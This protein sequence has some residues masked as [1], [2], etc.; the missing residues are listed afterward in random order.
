MSH[1]EIC[2]RQADKLNM[3][4]LYEISRSKLTGGLA[5]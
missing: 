3:Q 5:K 1:S 2:Y 4:R